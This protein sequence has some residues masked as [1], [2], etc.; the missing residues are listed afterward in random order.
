SQGRMDV[1]VDWYNAGWYQ[2]GPRPGE[3]GSAVIAGHLDTPTGD[4]SIFY[5]LDNLAT[6]D[7]VQVTDVTGKTL[8]FEVVDSQ[9]FSDQ[10]FPLKLVF[11]QNDAARLNLI[12]C[13]GT[14]D[15]SARNYSDRL[16]VFTKLVDTSS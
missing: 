12:T 10:N 8:T 5:N 4:T 6:G 9:V 15:Q 3:Q 1:P 13:T 2:Y 7:Q 11:E 16:V 14:F